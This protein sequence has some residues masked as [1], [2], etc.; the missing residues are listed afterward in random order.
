MKKMKTNKIF[1]TI[2]TAVF[3]CSA[4]IS[5]GGTEGLFNLT[6]AEINYPGFLSVSS[7]LSY[8]PK[9]KYSDSS[10][11]GT[12]TAFKTALNFSISK[13]LE[14]SLMMPWYRDRFGNS[15][16]AGAGDPELT[17]KFIYPPYPHSRIMELAF[18]STLFLPS[19][20]E[21]K[22]YYKK[23]IFYRNSQFSS[24]SYDISAMAAFTVN[25]GYINNIPLCFHINFGERFNTN[26]ET[27]NV[28]R[29]GTGLE[30]YKR[31]MYR[32]YLELFGETSAGRNHIDPGLDPLALSAGGSWSPKRYL[33]LSLAYSRS[34]STYSKNVGHTSPLG[35]EYRTRPQFRNTFS[36]RITLRTEVIPQDDDRDGISN[37]NDLCV[38]RPEDKDG[39]EDEDG[40][41]DEDNDKDRIKDIE[42]QCPLQPEDYD[43][44]EDEDGCPDEDNDKDGIKDIDD[45]CPLEPEDKDGFEDEDGCP[46]EDND[47]DG[48][49]DSDDKCPLEPE[50]YNNFND[51]DGCPDKG[52]K[53]IDKN[54][55]VLMNNVKFSPANKFMPESYLT[56]N[57]LFRTMET[58]SD[59]VIEIR[60]HTDSFGSIRSNRIKSLRRA[61]LIKKF[62][63]DRGIEDKRVR[64][65]GLGESVPVATN[66]TM[67]G[68]LKN[69]RIEILRIR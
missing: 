30:Y 37:T 49:K 23:H 47:K 38:M 29:A 33:D 63:T 60:G 10:S 48:I 66:K 12:A 16:E 59:Y 13:Y 65:K 25:F 15:T 50:N 44:F 43:G 41:P 1:I 53:S 14:T 58:F 18:F 26:V 36:F 40:C 9:E 51:K 21:E 69:N 8:S 5:S 42:D 34:F 31:N 61:R 2:L 28:Y 22:G 17:L 57:E 4:A 55:P 11:E 62:L 54:R 7:M 19:G 68:R 56:L 39:F 3:F 24:N 67:E 52:A 32:V 46:D 45:K 6:S 64:V 35:S 27:P 20:S